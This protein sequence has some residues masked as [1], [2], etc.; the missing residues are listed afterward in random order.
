MRFTSI[1][2][3]ALPLIGSVFAAPFTEKD[4]IAPAAELAK[5]DVDV[6]SVVNEVQ[7][8]VNAAAAM[9]YN[10]QADVEARLNTVIDAF[11]WCGDQLGIDV[12]ASASANA[13]VNIHYLRRE[14][15]AR[16]DD[17]QAVAQALSNVVQTVNVG[18]VQQI[19]YE[20][21][22]IPG[23]SNLVHQL[24]VALSL[25]LKGVDAILAGTLYLVKALLLDVGIILNAL[26]G[27]LLGIL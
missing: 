1:V 15:I 3:A 6:L 18:I 20:F 12:S 22:N 11:H 5:K 21:I 4:S 19:P 17:K 13:D 2:I 27:S 23:V 16:N 7:S 8:R 25:I 14:I 24:D 10:S 9:P 26:L